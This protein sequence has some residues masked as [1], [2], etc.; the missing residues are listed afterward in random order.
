METEELKQCES[1]KRWF[2]MLALKHSGSKRTEEVYIRSLR[3]FLEL[4]EISDPEIL[5]DQ[6]NAVKYDLKERKKVTDDFVDKIELFAGH[7]RN[8]GL[9][10]S[11]IARKSTA[12]KS[13]FNYNKVELDWK[14]IRANA[15][16]RDRLPTKEE[17]RRLFDYSH[18]SNRM[19]AIISTLIESGLRIGT[20]LQLTYGSIQKDYERSVV[21]CRVVVPRELTKG[22]THD[23]Y[24]FIGKNTIAYLR[25]YLE[26]RQ[27]GTK[28]LEPETLTPDSLLF[29]ANLKGEDKPIMKATV[30]NTLKEA[31]FKLDIIEDN[32]KGKWKEIHP[33]T[34]RKYFRTYMNPMGHSWVHFMM[35]H[36]LKNNDEIYFKA[37]EVINEARQIY[38]KAYENLDWTRKPEAK[39]LNG[40]QKKVASQG[41]RI[42]SLERTLER[43]KTKSKQDLQSEIHDKDAEL[44]Q[45]REDLDHFK[46]NLRERDAVISV[47]YDLLKQDPETQEK[48]RKLI[49][50][51]TRKTQD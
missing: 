7:L 33:H 29:K 23:Y 3:E 42:K 30:A 26:K 19:K 17:L 11:S 35:G 8:R 38:R 24:S 25:E 44:S 39:R 13:F 43:Y 49:T 40:L 4:H 14:P 15:K 18:M 34:L 28:T 12:I 2:N 45:L 46:Q 9:A 48:F 36:V 1:V 10:K 50:K 27:S 41:V 16:Y 6:Y 20:V 37:P 5:I 32:G 22:K 31:L 21:P 51:K 47:F